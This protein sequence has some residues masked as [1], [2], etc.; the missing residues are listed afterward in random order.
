MTNSDNKETKARDILK[1]PNTTSA[2]VLPTSV[3]ILNS[4]ELFILIDGAPFLKI[5]GEW[6]PIF[7]Q[8]L[9]ERDIEIRVTE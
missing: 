1:E 3:Q 7:G 8:K 4:K 9:T 5:T 2:Q 6:G